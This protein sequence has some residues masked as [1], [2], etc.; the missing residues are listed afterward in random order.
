M[1][2]ASKWQRSNGGTQLSSWTIWEGSEYMT[3]L[4]LETDNIE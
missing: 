2:L 3:T 1:S 4:K